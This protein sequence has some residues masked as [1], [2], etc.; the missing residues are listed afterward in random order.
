VLLRWLGETLMV[1]A[2]AWLPIMVL[3]AAVYS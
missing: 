1:L 3:I 2:L